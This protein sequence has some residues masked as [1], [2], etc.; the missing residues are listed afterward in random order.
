MISA[1]YEDSIRFVFEGVEGPDNDPEY[2]GPFTTRIRGL[3]VDHILKNL[4]LSKYDK[5]KKTLTEKLAELVR[6]RNKNTDLRHRRPSDSSDSISESSTENESREVHEEPGE[7][8]T[9]KKLLHIY[10]GAHFALVFRAVVRFRAVSRVF[11]QRCFFL[12]E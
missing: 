4:I 6:R 1:P 10:K 9:L 7:Q 11:L 2:R 5:K 3:R 12:L 8:E